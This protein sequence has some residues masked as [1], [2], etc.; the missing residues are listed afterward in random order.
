MR[1]CEEITAGDVGDDSAGHAFVEV[2][3]EAAGWGGGIVTSE[4]VGEPG[5]T[6]RTDFDVLAYF[7]GFAGFGVLGLYVFTIHLHISFIAPV[8]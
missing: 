8:P 2:R 3:A 5:Y 7:L 6:Q 4:V 1:D